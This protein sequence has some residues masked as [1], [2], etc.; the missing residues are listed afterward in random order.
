MST[1]ATGSTGPT[2][3]IYDSSTKDSCG[4]FNAFGDAQSAASALATAKADAG[5]D[6]SVKSGT[7][8]TGATGST[9]HYA[10][11]RTKNSS[12]EVT[13]GSYIYLNTSR[14]RLDTLYEIKEIVPYP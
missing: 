14:E 3:T 10:V 11:I 1:G 12:Y 6:L 9:I 4:Q 5:T 7:G 13:P 2:Y 8:A